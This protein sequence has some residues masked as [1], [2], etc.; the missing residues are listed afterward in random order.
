MRLLLV[1][2]GRERERA[3][4]RPST[5]TARF[6]LGRKSLRCGKGCHVLAPLG[7][8]SWPVTSSPLPWAETRSSGPQR[9]HF[10]LS[11]SLVEG[12]PS[13]GLFQGFPTKEKWSHP[14]GPRKAAVPVKQR[15]P[16]ASQK[17]LLLIAWSGV[18]LSFRPLGKNR[19]ELQRGEPRLSAS[20]MLPTVGTDAGFTDA[21]GKLTPFSASPL[22]QDF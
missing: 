7:F 18:R 14:P 6:N 8:Q 4:L 5:F 15:V 2:G 11:G 20:E 17:V 22:R 19:S 21:S 10:T 12:T 1:Q 16:G 13:L 9:R 3:S